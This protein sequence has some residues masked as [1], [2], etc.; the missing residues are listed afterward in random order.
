MQYR[1][2]GQSGVFNELPVVRPTYCHADDNDTNDVD[3]DA[4][5]V[6]R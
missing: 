3:V 5:D 1:V 6:E 4:V 2:A